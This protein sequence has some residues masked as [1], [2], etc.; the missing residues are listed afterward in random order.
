M[1]CA[2]DVNLNIS[3]KL[4]RLQFT[5]GEREQNYQSPMVYK[6]NREYQVA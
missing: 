3:K 6:G 2:D 4:T 1:S 5:R